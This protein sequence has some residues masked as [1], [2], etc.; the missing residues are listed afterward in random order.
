MK[1][2][3]KRK[4]KIKGKKYKEKIF[5]D[6]CLFLSPILAQENATKMESYIREVK[7]TCNCFVSHLVI[8]EIFNEI[9][10]NH[11]KDKNK[12]LFSINCVY[13]L[14]LL[15]GISIIEIKKDALLR[16]IELMRE[17]EDH[18][19]RDSIHLMVA[20]LSNMDRFVTSDEPLEKRFRELSKTIDFNMDL[21]LI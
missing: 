16:A 10:E 12:Q 6:S 14:E 2:H 19:G 1:F 21:R 3:K 8:G 15:E 17:G 5:L 11:K 7:K 9:L 4:K 13:A 20:E 18:D